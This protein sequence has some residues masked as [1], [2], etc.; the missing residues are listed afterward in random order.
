MK[1][2]FYSDIEKSLVKYKKC[3]QK[4]T[5]NFWSMTNFL[6]PT[7]LPT[8]THFTAQTVEGEEKTIIKKLILVMH[9][10]PIQE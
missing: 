9:F 5:E 4:K 3:F 10:I 7:T 8:W 6:S 2:L 1:S